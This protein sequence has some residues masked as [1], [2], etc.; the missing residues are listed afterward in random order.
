M[1]VALLVSGTLVSGPE[2]CPPEFS[3]SDISWV[4]IEP[5]I[6]YANYQPRT[7]NRAE[8]NYGIHFIEASFVPDQ[9]EFRVLRHKEE[10]SRLE[11][12]VDVARSRG[13]DV[14]VATN[15][16]YYTQLDTRS[17]PLGT[18]VTGGHLL[19]LKNG[20]PSLLYSS[21]HGFRIGTWTIVQEVSIEGADVAIK[22]LNRS[23]IRDGA[24]LYDGNYHDT[25]SSKSKCTMLHLAIAQDAVMVGRK[26]LA[27]VL[28]I[29]PG[30]K[31]ISLER[32]EF[33]LVL[34]GETKNALPSTVGGTATISTQVV[35][36]DNPVHEAVSGGPIVLQDGVH[37]PA[38]PVP[39]MSTAR[40]FYLKQRHPR[41]AVGVKKD[42]RDLLLLVAE[43]R[44]GGLTPFHTACLLR[45]VGAV[46]GML[47]DGGG[48]AALYVDGAFK[49]RPHRHR[50]R[51]V[52]KLANIISI[53]RVKR[54]EGAHPAP[55]DVD[56][57]GEHGDGSRDRNE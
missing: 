12:I 53:I 22:R 7:I 30:R 36:F 43:G 1:C 6:R 23:P 5:G 48:S 32:D 14:R 55:G 42:P 33:A 17:D 8:P 51:T 25:A 44:P 46:D 38:G 57:R 47:L 37:V 35:G 9:L 20:P 26:V 10:G 13:A 54:G 52:R 39:W 50:T 31:R 34:C 29:F 11:D 16:D 56:T 4:E 40:R 41:T 2:E 49:N 27:S 28:E 19:W 3:P 18:Y 24:T 45:S 21:Q 15:A